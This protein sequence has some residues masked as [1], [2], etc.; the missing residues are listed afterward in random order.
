[1]IKLTLP[2]DQSSYAVTD[3]DEVI[4]VT[5]SGGA[6]RVRRDVE[7]ATA[8]V[9]VQ[10]TVGTEEYHYLK[11]FY[12]FL[13]EKGSEPFLIDLYLDR[14]ILTEHES[15][16]KAGSMKLL[17]QRGHTYVVGA[18]LDAKPTTLTDAEEDNERIFA[19]LFGELGCGWETEFPV[20]ESEFD[21]IINIDLPATT[22]RLWYI[23]NAYGPIFY[24]GAGYAN[25][26]GVPIDG[27]TLPD[28]DP[29]YMFP[30]DPVIGQYSWDADFLI[31][32]WFDGVG[33]INAMGTAI[34]GHAIP[35]PDTGYTR[36]TDGLNGDMIYDALVQ[37]PLWQGIGVW[38]NIM[39]GVE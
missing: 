36:P 29:S 1:M 2:P 3:G 24:T 10:W 33:W 12:R 28:P 6:P 31:P 22:N 13:A 38:Y 8:S 25:G 21:T 19:I 39:Q 11:S 5:L 16:F 34:D 17:S 9:N 32:T 26:M 4:S 15:Y 37:L 35:A 7:G 30:A 23:H 14:E 20:L 27:H 18:S